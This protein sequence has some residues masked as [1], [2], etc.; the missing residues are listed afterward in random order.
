MKP[1]I[2]SCCGRVAASAITRSQ[3][4]TLSDT[5]FSQNTCLPACKASSICS[6]CSE[7]GVTSQT[8][9]KPSWA[10]KASSVS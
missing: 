7:V 4:T 1:I 2:T 6:A 9:S 10:S 5:G 8:A 3:S